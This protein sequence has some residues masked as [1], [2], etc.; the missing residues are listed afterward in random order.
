MRRIQASFA[1][2]SIS[3]CFYVKTEIKPKVRQVNSADSVS[4]SRQTLVTTA[5]SDR[6]T[7]NAVGAVREPP[8]Q[9]FRLPRA[10]ECPHGV[11]PSPACGRGVGERAC[12]TSP[13]A[14]PHK[15]PCARAPRGS[16]PTRE[17]GNDQSTNACWAG[18]SARHPLCLTNKKVSLLRQKPVCL[19]F[20]IH[21]GTTQTEQAGGFF[22]AI[23]CAFQGA[24]QKLPL[25]CGHFKG[26]GT[27]RT[28]RHE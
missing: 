12:G 15:P 28:G 19:Q 7:A 6:K 21:R 24:E 18:T 8:S 4:H 20:A 27:K 1:P 26:M 10:S 22:D 25:V 5:L 9:G 17:R 11:L 2:V 3:C 23:L 13:P 16:V 14:A